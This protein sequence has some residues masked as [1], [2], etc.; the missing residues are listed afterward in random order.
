VIWAWIFTIP[1][2][3]IVSALCVMIFEAIKNWAGA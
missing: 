1:G 3:A 2:A